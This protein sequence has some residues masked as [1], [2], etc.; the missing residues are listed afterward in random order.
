MNSRAII[1]GPGDKLRWLEAVA[2]HPE[3]KNF[4]SRLAI[5]LSN[6]ID[7]Y[8]GTA[9][10][11]QEW[12]AR[13]TS[14]TVRGVR[15]GLKA[16]EVVCLLMVAR[17]PNGRGMSAVYRPLRSTEEARNGGPR[18]TR[19][20][21]TKNPERESAKPGTPVPIVPKTPPKILQGDAL[22][23]VQG[24][25]PNELTW[26]SVK[27]KLK[28]SLGP[29]KVRAWFDPLRV[30]AIL[31]TEV[32]MIAP[33]KF[34]KHWIEQHPFEL[35]LVAGWQRFLPS[36]TRVRLVVATAPAAN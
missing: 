4:H 23:V 15:K 31:Q 6:R 24:R 10:I 21:E 22:Q 25:D 32:V 8:E 35:D 34:H 26:Q 2:F 16:M 9:T 28:A 3:M 14:A 7:K 13:K 19:N 20:D 5:A 36:I 18:E 30:Q 17:A 1:F 29:D 11:S 27:E 12:L 33:T